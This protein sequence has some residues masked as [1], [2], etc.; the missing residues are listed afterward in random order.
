MYLIRLVLLILSRQ[1]LENKTKSLTQCVFL[2]VGMVGERKS[3]RYVR[4]MCC[5]IQIERT[6]RTNIRFYTEEIIRWY[7]DIRAGNSYT[8]KISERRVEQI[9]VKQ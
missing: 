5:E 4:V 9:C 7:K 6:S 1:W 3:E 8:V 2:G